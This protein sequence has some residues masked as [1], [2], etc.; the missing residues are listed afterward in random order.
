MVFTFVYMVNKT[1]YLKQTNKKNQ[2]FHNSHLMSIHLK[3]VK[4]FIDFS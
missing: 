1:L 2:I 4:Y 3:N